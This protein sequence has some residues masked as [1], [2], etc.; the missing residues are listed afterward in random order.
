MIAPAPLTAVVEATPFTFVFVFAGPSSTDLVLDPGTPE[1]ASPGGE[2]LLV[3]LAEVSVVPPGTAA[4]EP[5]AKV[6]V[7]GAP[8][9]DVLTPGT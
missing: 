8:S 7:T 1:V 9:V 3:S 5:L 6:V 4:D 2:E